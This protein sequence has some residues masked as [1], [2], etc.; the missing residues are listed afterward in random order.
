MMLPYGC[1][2]KIVPKLLERFR[3][4]FGCRISCWRMGIAS[5]VSRSVA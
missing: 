2:W 5:I 1:G 4:Y 3:G